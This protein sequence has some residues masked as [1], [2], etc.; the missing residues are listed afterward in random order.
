MGDVKVVRPLTGNVAHWREVTVLSRVSSSSDKEQAY[1]TN[2]RLCS[3]IVALEA[4]RSVE[5]AV[6]TTL[7]GQ[8]CKLRENL[9]V[10]MVFVYL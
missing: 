7:R 8:H 2:L 6:K 4:D 10:T 1:L 9:H 3:D 5:G